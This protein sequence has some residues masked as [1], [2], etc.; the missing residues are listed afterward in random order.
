MT[1]SLV[2][3]DPKVKHVV[4]GRRRNNPPLECD[5]APTGC[6]LMGRPVQVWGLL[7]TFTPPP[8]QSPRASPP[9]RHRVAFTDTLVIAASLHTWGSS[10]TR[11]IVPTW[12]HLGST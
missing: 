8:V 3:L 1:D 11:A 9:A 12:L 4:A 10:P 7:S 6:S 2:A 5:P